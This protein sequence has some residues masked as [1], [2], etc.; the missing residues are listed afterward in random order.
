V[1]RGLVVAAF[2]ASLV[3][4]MALGVSFGSGS[5]T[6]ADL[7][8][9]GSQAYD[10]VVG[11]RVPRVLLG[12]VAG[13]GLSAVG[14]A[15]QTLL[16]NPLA[17]PYVLGISGGAGLAATI[18]MGLGAAG[19]GVLGAAAVPVAAFVGG[20]A[21]TAVVW[22]LVRSGRGGEASIL[23]AGVV[24][25]SIAGACTTLLES[26]AEPGRL[27]S[28]L[29]W[30]MGFLDVPSPAQLAFVSLYVA[31][32]LGVLAA[33]AARM[34]L[35]ALGEEAAATLG[36]DVRALERRTLFA[37]AVVV[38]AIVSATGLIGFVGLVVPQAVRRTL[39]P[40]LRVA[41]PACVLGGG[42]VVVACDLFV[43]VL[44]PRIHTEIPVGAVTA[45]LGGP[46]FLSLL[47]RR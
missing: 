14:A 38:G 41:L 6:A 42:A 3:V 43:R 20:I 30:L 21:A 27:Q 45:L 5:A 15:F 7:L 31:G 36:L 1:R 16:K 10:I 2:A 26:I 18:A 39:G 25:N 4:A 17:E 29:W 9:P 13:A 37:C 44:A 40:D 33:D 22:G 34:N 12:V 28:V 8:R 19:A 23:L 11:Y 32:G 47:R 24:V 46:L 35:L